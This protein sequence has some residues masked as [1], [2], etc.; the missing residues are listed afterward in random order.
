[1][2][3][4]DTRAR[5]VLIGEELLLVGCARLLRKRGFNIAAILSASPKIEA[6]ARDHGVRCMHPGRGVHEALAGIDYDYLFS[7]ANL[8]ILPPAVIQAARLGAIN[9][10]DGPLPERAGV[11]V[12]TWTL[13]E[14]RQYHAVTWHRMMESID[15]GHVLRRTPVS[16]DD[17]DTSLTLNTKCHEA[18]IASFADLLDDLNSDSREDIL[19]GTPQNTSNRTYYSRDLRPTAAG[20]IDWGQD[21]ADIDALVR[22]LDFGTYSNPFGS[23]KLWMENEV[24]IVAGLDRREE[25][26]GLSPGTV[27]STP[28]DTTMPPGAFE[29]ALCVATATKDVVLTRLRRPDGKELSVAEFA[30]RHNLRRGRRLPVLSPSQS[31][32][33]ETLVSETVRHERLWT[34]ALENVHPAMI[35][36]VDSARGAK[37]AATSSASTRSPGQVRFESPSAHVRELRTLIGETG[38][39]ARDADVLAALFATY[40][41]RLGQKPGDYGFTLGLQTAELTRQVRGIE[42]L[43]ADRVPW[44]IQVDSDISGRDAIRQVL[45]QLHA[46]RRQGTYLL[47][48]VGRTPG[49]GRHRQGVHTTVDIYIESEPP[50]SLPAGADLALSIGAEGMQTWTFNPSSLTREEVECLNDQCVRFAESLVGAPDLPLHAHSILGDDDLRTLLDTWNDTR[51]DYRPAPVHRQFEAQ[52]E[53][54]PNDP[55]LTVENRTLSYRALNL[56][57]N[58]VAH[59]LIDAGVRPGDRVGVCVDRSPDMVAAL[60]GIWKAGA[61]YVPLDPLYPAERIGFMVRDADLACVITTQARSHLVRETGGTML[62]IDRDATLSRGPALPP[63]GVDDDPDSVAYVMYTSGSTGT[64]KGVMVTHRNVANFFAGMDDR[65]ERAGDGSDVWLAVT[66]ISFD[67]SVL[68]LFWTLTRGFTVVLQGDDRSRTGARHDTAR[69][70]GRRKKTDTTLPVSLSLIERDIRFSLFYF[71]SDEKL[72]ATHTGRAREKYQLL[73]DGAV[74]GDTHGFDAV[75]TPERHFHDFGGLYPNPSV[76]SAAIA[77]KTEKIHIRAGSCV[78]PLHHPVRIAEDWAVVDNLSNGRVG[79][80]FAAGWQPNDFVLQPHNFADRKARMFEQIEQVRALWRGEACTFP[81]PNGQ[82]VEVK[83]LPRPVQEE[84]P[85]WVTA[86]GN[87]QTFKRAGQGGYNL[88]THLLGQSVDELAEK[89]DLYRRARREAGHAGRGRVTLMLHTFVGEN[90]ATV[91]ETVCEPMKRY[92]K[93]SIGLIKEAAWSFPTFKQKTTTPS[94]DFSL[95]ALTDAEM[96]AVLEHAF[97]R[98]YATGGLFGTPSQCIDRVAQ[99]AEAGVDEI[100]CLLDFGIDPTTVLDHLPALTEVKNRV[101]SLVRANGSRVRGS[102]QGNGQ[103]GTDSATQGPERETTDPAIHEASISENIEQHRVTHLQCTPSQARMLVADDRTR[104]SLQRLRHMMVG[105]EA[106][107]PDLAQTLRGLVSGRVTNMYGPTE[108]TIWS[109]TGEVED[110]RDTVPIGTPIANTSVYLLDENRQPVPIGL[111]GDLWIGGAGVTKGYLNRP[112]LTA[113]RFVEDP[114]RPGGRMYK[115]G[116]RARFAAD[117]TLEFLGRSD[118]QVKIRGH[119]VELGEIETQL[120]RHPAVRTAVVC[121]QDNDDA[122]RRLVAYL[123]P[124]PD[125]DVD[126]ADIRAYLSGTLPTIMIPVRYASVEHLPLTPNGKI[127]RAA[128]SETDLPRPSADAPVA[129]ANDTE[130]VVADVWSAVLQRDPVG[131]QENFFDLGGHSLLAVQV[132]RRLAERL[133]REVSIVDL[134]QHPTVRALARRLSVGRDAAATGASRGLSRA[135]RRRLARR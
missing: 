108:T 5:C 18:G 30:A 19:R 39:T 62:L 128:L 97:G 109:T 25:R 35:P 103:T 7:I 81:G 100:A 59:W 23:A 84:V 119:R 49:L 71:S 105:G 16:V 33:I 61:G 34:D 14:R 107:P 24:A 78:S 21:A 10:H 90:E 15:T 129:P 58:R 114:F 41:H 77:S 134:F 74:Y 51:T 1:M 57:A 69:T 89:I 88:L 98:Y 82:P 36:Y 2:S 52:V 86:A 46:T 9:F 13:I 99:V 22:A 65:I 42:A 96:D 92:L 117:G 120:E 38:D 56:R 3:H 63:T 44:T 60:F 43:F 83:T 124:E 27:V 91:R 101:C 93:S 64:P 20:L 66:S 85:V 94:G 132:V 122:D 106:F 47:D 127:D 130:R 6:W 67:I 55:A 126:A 123:Q 112:E 76:I 121:V 53:R 12:P 113:D 116:D 110:I 17:T 75:W 70:N 11:H 4:S 26:S 50:A 45:M 40:L 79:I 135:E 68:E 104:T 102:A 31:K 73:L 32:K 111:S 37:D 48:L 118:H 133:N 131:V 115:T 29:N 28:Q 125:A 54:T 80:S 8:R 87:P 72:G 95:D